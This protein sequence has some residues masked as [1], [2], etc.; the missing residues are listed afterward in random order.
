MFS[1]I[2]TGGFLTFVRVVQWGDSCSVSSSVS[3]VTD[4]PVRRISDTLISISLLCPLY[5]RV[6]WG[7]PVCGVHSS[8]TK[9]LDKLKPRDTP[10]ILT[11]WKEILNDLEV[12][13]CPLIPSEFDWSPP[14]SSRTDWDFLMA[15]I[16]QNLCGDVRQTLMSSLDPNWFRFLKCISHRHWSRVKIRRMQ[17]LEYWSDRHPFKISMIVFWTKISRNVYKCNT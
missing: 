9:S 3:P 14:F 1:K 6:G 12:V 10:H 16:F 15:Q 2:H 5:P 7:F 8:R 13:T 11:A 4:N 17:F